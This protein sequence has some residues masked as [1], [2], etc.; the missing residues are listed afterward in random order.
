MFVTLVKQSQKLKSVSYHKLYD[1]LKQHQNEKIRAERLVYTA[2]PLKLVAQQQLVYHPTHYTQNSSTR[3]Q[4]AATRNKE[5]V[6]VNSPQPIYDQEPK[7]VV[8]DDALSKEK[9]IDKL[10]A[11]I[12]LSF[13]KIYKPTNNNL[14]TSSNTSRENQDNTPRINI[15]TSYDN[16]RD[17]N[18][19][20]AMENVVNDTYPDEQG[21]TNIPTDS[22]DISNNRGEATQDEDEDLARERDL[23]ASLIEK[24]KCEIDESKYRNKLLE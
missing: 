3:P 17:V 10:I 7:M 13:N 23:L 18:I 6:I 19:V 20:G 22:L 24:L 15:G 21:N 4:Q 5:K 12:S 2:N 14:K 1:I 11:L 8:E 16:Q 9:E